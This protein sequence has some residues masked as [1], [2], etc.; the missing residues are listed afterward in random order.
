MLYAKALGMTIKLIASSKRHDD[1][2]HANRS[3]D[4]FE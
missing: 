2:V 3:S 1:H 4:A